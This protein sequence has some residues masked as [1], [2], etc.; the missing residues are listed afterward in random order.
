MRLRLDAATVIFVAIN[1]VVV[2]I[3]AN[4]DRVKE[5]TPGVM[6]QM[7]MAYCHTE[8]RQPYNG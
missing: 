5:S 7:P 3:I 4:A 1:D 6:L 8:G 2:D